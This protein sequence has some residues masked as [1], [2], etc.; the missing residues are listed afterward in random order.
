[1]IVDSDD[2][3]EYK[4]KSIR[5]LLS[6]GEAPNTSRIY[7]KLLGLIKWA[8]F[9]GKP[10]KN[11]DT[12]T[13]NKNNNYTPVYITFTKRL[14]DEFKYVKW[15]DICSFFLKD[16]LCPGSNKP[17]YTSFSI[18]E[19][20]YSY[21]WNLAK[22]KNKNSNKKVHQDPGDEFDRRLISKSLWNY[23]NE[24]YKL[25]LDMEFINRLYPDNYVIRDYY[26]DLKEFL[27]EKK[28]T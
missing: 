11:P 28:T 20:D 7:S 16:V 2:F 27:N 23:F 6:V 25:H 18:Y 4:R 9:Y 3:Q 22:I 5:T 24:Q 17:A 8:Y 19:T 12:G 14:Y 21:T 1:M 15:S 13:Y 26:D 10:L